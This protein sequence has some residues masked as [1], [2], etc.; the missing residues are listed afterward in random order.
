MTARAPTEVAPSKI[1]RRLGLVLAITIVF[2]LLIP[3]LIAAYSGVFFLEGIKQKINPTILTSWQSLHDQRAELEEDIATIEN[4]IE[5][6]GTSEGVISELV[7]QKL[8]YQHELNKLPRISLQP[9]YLH[10]VSYFWPIMFFCLTSVIFFAKPPIKDKDKMAEM[11]L[12]AVLTL[13]TYLAF[14]V[15]L[16]VR[17]NFVNTPGQGRI[18]YAFSNPD[19]SRPSFLVQNLN[20]LVFAILLSI[21]WVQWATFAW[22]CYLN[23]HDEK[24]INHDANVDLSL[25]NEARALLLRWQVVFVIISAGFSVFS[26]IS[27]TQIFRNGDYRFVFEGLIAHFIWIL[28]IFFTALPLIIVWR[29]WDLYKSSMI[30]SIINKPWSNGDHENE[31]LTFINGM[32]PIGSW[33]AVVTFVTVVSSFLLPIVQAFLKSKGV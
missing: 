22:Q 16:F 3:A 6:A 19:I 25:L 18:V 23:I 27:W 11:P 17:T 32:S 13:I 12:T 28:T 26:A 21:I 8:K 5:N 29:G 33:N 31:K 2:G 1:L 10:I 4:S 24:Y 15:P 20:F 9:Y 14:V 7:K 30:A